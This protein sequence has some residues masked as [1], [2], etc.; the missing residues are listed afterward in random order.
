M[1]HA[2]LLPETPSL[3]RNIKR[4]SADRILHQILS[5][6]LDI[7]ILPRCLLSVV[8]INWPAFICFTWESGRL[9][10]RMSPTSCRPKPPFASRDGEM[11]HSKPD[12][13]KYSAHDTAK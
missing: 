7:N 6:P 5:C 1:R 10:E 12:P 3:C 8:R 13:C 9:E 11:I 2:Q 4:L